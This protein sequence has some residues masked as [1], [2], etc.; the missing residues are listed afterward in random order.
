MSG[1]SS[2]RPLSLALAFTCVVAW[3]RWLFEPSCEC[4]F[5]FDDHLGVLN[6]DD[7]DTGKTSAAPMWRH[8]IWGKELVKVDSHKSW[9]PLLTFSFRL[10]HAMEGG[11]EARSFR[12]LGVFVSTPVSAASNTA[13]SLPAAS[14]RCLLLRAAFCSQYEVSDAR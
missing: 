14:Q 3:A 11:F 7:V 10:S 1:Y 4:D 9:R 8:D 13:P 5:T 12:N 2:R 6:N